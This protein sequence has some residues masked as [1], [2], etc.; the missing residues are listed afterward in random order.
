[1]TRNN[2]IRKDINNVIEHITATIVMNEH[3]EEFYR[4]SGDATT[5]E[6]I[7]KIMFDAADNL[8]QSRLGLE[9]LKKRLQETGW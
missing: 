3:E 8:A 9:A 2:N 6:G 4:R 1:M 5:N 7:R